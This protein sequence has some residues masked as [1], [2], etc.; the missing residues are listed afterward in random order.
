MLRIIPLV[1]AVGTMASTGALAQDVKV[2][3]VLPLTG[4][5]APVGKQVQAG[6]KLYM[7]KNGSPAPGEKNDLITK[8]NAGSDHQP[9]PV[10]HELVVNPKDTILRLSQYPTAK[11]I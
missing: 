9:H 8:D 6:I 4:G 7:D 10:A 11:G 3:V 5:L 2:G 1:L